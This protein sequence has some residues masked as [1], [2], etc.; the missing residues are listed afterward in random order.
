MSEKVLISVGVIIPQDP[1]EEV[2]KGDEIIV[3]DK[4]YDIPSSTT[5]QQIVQTVLIKARL[6]P[7]IP[8]GWTNKQAFVAVSVEDFE[9]PEEVD[10]LYYKGQYKVPRTETI[11]EIVDWFTASAS[12]KRYHG[13]PLVF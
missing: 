2:E 4:V 3:H 1:K 6:D 5:V 7:N 10:L 11:G 8:P 9:D 12:A 13:E